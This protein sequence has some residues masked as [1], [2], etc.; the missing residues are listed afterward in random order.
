MGPKEMVRK[1]KD[2]GFVL[3]KRGKKHDVYRKG[4]HLVPI[5]R[6]TKVFFRTLIANKV[7][8]RRLD[9]MEAAPAI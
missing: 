3:Y 9:R 7:L 1:L 6:G 4:D 8:I 5:S 2:A